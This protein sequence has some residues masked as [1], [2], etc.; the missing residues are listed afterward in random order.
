MTEA[1]TTEAA[2]EALEDVFPDTRLEELT[3]R[4]EEAE[5]QENWYDADPEV[6]WNMEEEES[7]HATLAAVYEQAGW[8]KCYH[9]VGARFHFNVK[10]RGNESWRAFQEAIAAAGV[11]DE[12]R[13][14]EI[15]ERR[16]ESD[17]EVFWWDETGDFLSELGISRTLH[18]LGRGIQV[19][20]CGRSGGYANCRELERD[21]EDFLKLAQFLARSHSWYDSAEYARGT[22]EY[23]LE[24][25]NEEKLASLASPRI[26]RIEA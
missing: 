5:E 14:R 9:R 16:Q 1:T 21:P 11:E 19:F 20:S 23:A 18:Q 4:A 26:E 25:Y 15:A 7:Y 17:L 8:E 2:T 12:E 22:V 3:R 10:L 6:A 24:Q 13:L